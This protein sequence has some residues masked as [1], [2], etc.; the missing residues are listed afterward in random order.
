MSSTT[1]SVIDVST[2]TTAAANNLYPV[3]L[4]LENLRTLVVGGGN[5]GLEKISSLRKF[6]PEARLTIVA[7]EIQEAIL[8]QVRDQQ[9]I[10]YCERAFEESDLD[11]QD[12]V[13]LATEN[14]ALNSHI[15]ELARARGIL[16]N[17]ADTPDECDF[18]LGSIVQKGQLKIAISTN[19]KSPTIAKR[20]KEVLNESFPEEVNDL[21]ENM[22]ALRKRLKGD[23]KDKVVQLNDL[24]KT[25]VEPAAEQNKGEKKWKRIATYCLIGFGLMIVG[26]YIFSYIQLPSIS[27]IASAISTGADKSFLLFLAVG[28]AAQMVDGALGMGYGVTSTTLLMSMGISPASISGSVHTAEMFSSGFSGYSHYKFG[29]VNKKLFRVL[30]IPG[31]IGAVLGAVSLVMLGEKYAAY[32]KPVI[33]VYCMILGIR[34]LY[35]AFKKAQKPKKIKKAG[36]LA[37]IGG[38][39][40]SFGGG[41]WGPLVTSTL[42]SKGRSPRFVIGSVSL[43]EFFVTL[44]SAFSFFA[45]IGISHWKV[46]VGLMLGGLIAAPIAARLAGKLPV[47][48]MFISVGVLVI[49]WSVRIL[50]KVV[51]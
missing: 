7:P 2:E 10:Q 14:R 30:L 13:I 1:P 23:F 41:G 49:I 35:Q 38:F 8:E 24:T 40:D 42:I 25:L 5:V 36:W 11:G 4:K 21:L 34:I 31:I 9:Y 20:V 48:A 32:I 17:V 37:G 43:S 33:A 19:G 26:Y 39:L 22:S 3:F 46:I 15:R 12:L 28:F 29:N 16:C 51:F 6:S 50:W 27:T 44:A 18:Y 45:L 47:K